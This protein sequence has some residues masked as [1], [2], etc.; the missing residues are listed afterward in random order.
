MRHDPF[1]EVV[2]ERHSERRVAVSSWAGLKVMPLAMSE[3]RIGATV[4]TFRFMTWA[5]SPDRWGSTPECR[6][7]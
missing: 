1:H 4:V 3:L 6:H 7:G 5:M 2:E